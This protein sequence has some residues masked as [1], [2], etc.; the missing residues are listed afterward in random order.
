MQ[1][2]AATLDILV[3]RNREI[4]KGT[5]PHALDQAQRLGCYLLC[6]NLIASL[7]PTAES[8][9]TF[10]STVRS[11]Q[12]LLHEPGCCSTLTS[13]FASLLSLRFS[14]LLFAYSLDYPFFL[15]PLLPPAD[16]GCKFSSTVITLLCYSPA[17]KWLHRSVQ[18]VVYMQVKLHMASDIFK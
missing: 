12:L 8:P 6:Q 11:W 15:P 13:M 1:I 2:I 18:L 5:K 4:G 9:C 14:R 16:V 10:D 17:L 3:N 7:L